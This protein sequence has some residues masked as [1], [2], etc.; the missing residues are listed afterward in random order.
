MK[1]N[2][3]S[4]HPNKSR[5]WPASRSPLANVQS[6][7][8]SGLEIYIGL[9]QG[10]RRIGLQADSFIESIAMSVYI[11]IYLSISKIHLETI[12]C[13]TGCFVQN[14][15][16]LQRTKIYIWHKSARV[17]KIPKACHIF[18]TF[19]PQ[20]DKKCFNMYAKVPNNNHFLTFL[21][22]DRNA[23]KKNQNRNMDILIS[24]LF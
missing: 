8:L 2:L 1:Q 3:Q 10:F 4:R 9:F 22:T 11:Y 18:S 24:N 20:C 12:Y 16:T 7:N 19:G 14:I 17:G 13:L 15:C 21:N 5:I 23:P 6:R